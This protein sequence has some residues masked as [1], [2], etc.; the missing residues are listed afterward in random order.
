MTRIPQ[1]TEENILLMLRAG[2]KHDE[3]ARI[4][5]VSETT[6][7]RVSTRNE[8]SKER[9]SVKNEIKM[10]LLKDWHWVVPKNPN[11][12]KKRKKTNFRTP[13]NYPKMW[14]REEQK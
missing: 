9:L 10:M 2:M 5:K 3:I 14:K 7:Q 13:Y 1:E 4:A 8:I 12:P 11:P 6:V